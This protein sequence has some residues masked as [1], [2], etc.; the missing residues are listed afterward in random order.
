MVF[1]YFL[2]F[3]NE[4]KLNMFSSYSESEIKMGYKYFQKKDNEM[5]QYLF[6]SFSKNKNEI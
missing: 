4:T 5:K 3:D 6:P 1:I 2:K